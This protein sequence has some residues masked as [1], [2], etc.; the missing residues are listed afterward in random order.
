MSNWL[1]EWLTKN[2]TDEQLEI[3]RVA[4]FDRWTWDTGGDADRRLYDA[5]Q[6]E[7]DLRKIPPTVTTLTMPSIMAGEGVVITEGNGTITISVDEEKIVEMAAE[8]IRNDV[9][10]NILVALAEESKHGE[11]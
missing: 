6:A 3:L 9:E 10:A 1:H 4:V 2:L 5:L 7:A 8:R 11:L